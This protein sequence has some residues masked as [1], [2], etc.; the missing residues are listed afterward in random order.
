MLTER[1][2]GG[3]GSPNGPV[4]LSLPQTLTRWAGRQAGSLFLLPAVLLLMLMSIF[5]LLLSV[6]LSLVRFQLVP[7]G[8]KLIFVGLANYRKLVAGIE[9]EH[10][11]GL[12]ADLTP[13]IWGMG[14]AVTAVLLVFVI[15]GAARMRPAVPRTAGRLV[16]AVIAGALTWLA[17]R[18]LA[19]GGRPG[20]VI[21]T[22]LYVF[23]GIAVQYWLGLILAYLAAQQ[24]PGR[25]FFR[26]VYLLPMMI[27]P[28]GIAYTFRI[29]ADLGKGP[30]APLW[31]AVGLAE[32]SW[33]G[34]AWGARIVVMIGDI[35]QWTP[36]MFIV[37]LAALEAQPQELLEA[38][39]MDGAGR[40]QTF[41]KVTWPQILPVTSTVI[42]IRMI[43]AFKII[44]L[45]N[46]LT[47]G[48][49]GTAT[50]SLTLHAF[51]AWRT[52]DIGGSAA[53]AYSLLFLV[54][55]M[56]LSYI[57]LVHRRLAGAV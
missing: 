53:V 12:L 36:F 30:F 35:W 48:G 26:V 28:V 14:G 2:L 27:T 25:R 20:T 3:T 8:F 52:L 56:A 7:G 54:T 6:Y 23:V 33:A 1:D 9:R 47:N 24:I 38:A 51:I 41:W 13:L 4:P 17:I 31:R 15:R 37:L 18:T 40:W 16:F 39:M 42:L 55:F 19:P 5:P 34:H 49:P 11:L 29:M 32:V 46:V 43:E 10:F 45:P 50:E 57:S 21:T 44:D 22:M